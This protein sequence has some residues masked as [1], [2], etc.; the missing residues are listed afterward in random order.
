MEF[1]FKKMNIKQKDIVLLPYPFTNLEGSKVRP[2]IVISNDTF[3]KK[4][5]D[6]IAIPL[7]TII[8]EVPY[9]IIIDQ[10]DLSYGK[11]IKPSRIRIDKIFTVEKKS[12]IMKIGVIKDPTFSKIKSELMNVF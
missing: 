12:I 4:S 6:C 7:T 11:L 1:L 9:S 3:N 2:A 8:K 5:D 10:T